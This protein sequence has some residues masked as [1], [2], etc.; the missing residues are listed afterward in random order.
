[1]NVEEWGLHLSPRNPPA[2]SDPK[3]AGWA[4]TGLW[5]WAIG[6]SQEGELGT[7]GT[8]RKL[9]LGTSS[10]AQP[11]RVCKSKWAP[12]PA[13]L[14]FMHMY[15]N[16]KFTALTT[17]SQIGTFWGCCSL[18]L[19]VVLMEVTDSDPLPTSPE[20]ALYRTSVGDESKGLSS[21][22]MRTH[23]LGSLLEYRFWFSGLEWIDPFNYCYLLWLY[24]ICICGFFSKFP[25]YF[26][27]YEESA[28]NLHQ[29]S[30]KLPAPGNNLWLLSIISILL[31]TFYEWVISSVSVLVFSLLIL[32]FKMKNNFLIEVETK[33][34]ALI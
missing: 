33:R 29:L 13:F 7:T 17:L 20:A 30:D 27:L 15:R 18:L 11:S 2:A 1:M 5:C 3:C 16:R 12:Q 8:S 6:Q 19:H 10:S 14:C 24:V 21:F 34:T 23:C 22:S 4:S 32:K 26:S 9:L 25:F 31:Y 28:E